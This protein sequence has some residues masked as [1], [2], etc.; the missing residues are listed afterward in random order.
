MSIIN[1]RRGGTQPE[2]SAPY[3]QEKLEY[4]ADLL[5]ELRAMA[6]R[7]GCQ[8]LAKMLSL[9][10]TEAVKAARRDSL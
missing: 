4:V 1:D 6:E 10:H 2:E 3:R 8:Q 5:D 7:E 9:S